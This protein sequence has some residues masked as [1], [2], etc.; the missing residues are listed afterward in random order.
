MGMPRILE[1]VP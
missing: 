1:A